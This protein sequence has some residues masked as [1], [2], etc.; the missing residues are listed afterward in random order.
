MPSPQNRLEI[1]AVCGSL[2]NGSLNAGLIRALQEIAE[3]RGTITIKPVDGIGDLPLIK[4]DH[5]TAGV[6]AA[7]KH[8]QEQIE[9]ADGVIIATP[10]YCYTVPAAL[11][12]FFEWQ[13]LP[14]PTRNPLRHKP[15]AVM[16]ASPGALGAYRAQED[17]R[18]IALHSDSQLL[19]RP[20]IY[21]GDA[22]QKFDANGRLTD[23]ATHASLERFLDD[24]EEFARATLDRDLTSL[25]R[26]YLRT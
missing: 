6:P 4:I 5:L 25:N 7:V 21:V 11:K 3:R 20:E 2:R 19:G 13:T 12:N 14:D 9:Q 24:Y 16:G 18:K 23:E 15:L 26:A 22:E 10:E 8:V 17:V 1:A